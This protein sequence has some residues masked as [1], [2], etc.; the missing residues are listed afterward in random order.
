MEEPSCTAAGGNDRVVDDV[1][2]SDSLEAVYSV[3]TSAQYRLLELIV[4]YDRED[5]WEPDG[6]RDFA[7]WL[8]M[9]LGI[10]SWAAR[11]WI[12]AAYT[13]PHLPRIGEELKAGA[14]SL[15]KTV[16]LCR[17]ATPQD[18]AK[19]IRWAKRVT[20]SGIRHRA[21]TAA[22]IAQAEAVEVDRSRYLNYYFYDEGKRLGLEGSFPAADGAVIAKALD[23]LAHRA[24]DIIED[25]DAPPTRPED[26]LSVRRADALVAL[27]SSAIATDQ[28]PDR[29]TV[30]VH[31]PLAAL[32]GDD[33]SCEIE[34]GGVIHPETARRLSCDSR[35]ESVLY[36]D[37]GNA[38]GIG[39][40]ARVV[41]AYLARQLR[42][43]DR[44]C[45][46][47][48]CGRQ[49]Y[50]H[51][52]HI[53]HWAIGGPTDLDN[54]V[55]VCNHHHK[56]VHEHRWRVELDPSGTAVWYRPNGERFSPAPARAAPRIET[57]HERRRLALPLVATL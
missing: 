42:Y 52:H 8:S 10:S 5:I 55:L 12:N 7:H 49:W 4:A 14:L 29:A 43:R 54:L 23:R 34:G 32:M 35:L 38:L 48:G 28:D 30:V 19:L 51:T 24:P 37:D 57:E 46:F 47:D 22:R 44:G 50:L 11:R 9:R 20:I 25:D 36:G 27:A 17:F 18:E 33:H 40:A 56:L 16:E 45:T 3:V 31:A 41:P 15:E 13:L 21:D 39:R 53:E 1:A 2:H 26:S 6:C